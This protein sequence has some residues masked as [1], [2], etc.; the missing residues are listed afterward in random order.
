M[1]GVVSL[2]LMMLATGL[3]ACL[4]TPAMSQGVLTQIVDNGPIEARLNVVIFSEGYT[5][6]QSA[7]FES[8]ALELTSFILTV[9]PFAEYSSYFNVFTIWVPSIESGSDHPLSGIYRNTYLN[10]TYDSYGITRLITI[11]PNDWDPIWA[12][13]AGRVYS[14]LETH[15]P[16]YD[17]VLIVVNDPEYG[18][19][20]GAFAIS[21]VH[22]TAPEIVLHELGHSFGSLADEY[23]SYTPGYSGHESPNTTAQ[24]IRELI[25]WNDWILQTT[26]VPTPE[27]PEYAEFVGLFEGACYETEGWYRPKLNCK[28]KSLYYDFCDV[29]REQLVRS[30]YQILSPIDGY[31]PAASTITLSPT[32]TMSLCVIPKMP[33]DHSLDVQWYVDSLPVPDAST[34]TFLVSTSHLGAGTHQVAAEV[35]DN[36]TLVRTD[37]YGLLRDSQTWTVTCESYCGDPDGNRVVDI[38]DVVFLVAYIFSGGA[39]PAPFESGDADC[40]GAVDIDDVVF[41]VSYIFSGGG[42]PCDTDGDGTPDC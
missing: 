1:T 5:F 27:T 40:S 31:L 33:S 13:G 30:Q 12:N 22:E 37:P 35:T 39:E 18:G 23:D 19:S 32:D 38:D 6:S 9:S 25:K 41:L 26:P 28:M 8:D 10:S 2:R 21:S 29:C 14:L 15:M 16:E 11:P 17:I 7:A 42:A 24:T 34:S 20:G 36:T 3:L 4:Y